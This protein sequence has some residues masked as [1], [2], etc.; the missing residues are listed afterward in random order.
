MNDIII[1]D[2]AVSIFFSDEIEKLLLEKDFS[3]YY[4]D[5]ITYP[6]S[7]LEKINQ[8]HNK[9]SG[10]GN[11]M[12]DVNGG[13]GNFY[14]FFTPILLQGLEKTNLH[15]TQ[16]TQVRSFLSLPLAITGSRVDKPHIDNPRP[17]MVGLYYVNDSDGDTVI[18]QESYNYMFDNFNDLK[19]F[20]VDNMPV[21]KSVTPKKGRLVIF[22]GKQYHAST[23]PTIGPRCIINFNF[24]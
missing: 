19:K 5:D 4:R 18:F 12:Y 21:L 11:L 14:S 13:I 7:A 9:R 24:I 17:H 16:I 1:I 15:L 6:N 8:L 3:W 2:N 23:Q 20:D 22:N 10:F